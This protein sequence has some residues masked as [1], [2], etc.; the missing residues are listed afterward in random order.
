MTRL[1]T[2]QGRPDLT[3]GPYVVRFIETACVHGPGDVLGRQVEL[4]AEEKRFLYWA[5]ELEPDGRRVVR[6]AV[7]G[8]PK[9]S[10]KTEFAAWLAIAEMVGPVRCSGFDGDGNPVPVQ[11][12]DP[13]IPV[14]AASFE[15]ADLMFGAVR[16]IIKASPILEPLFDVY[17]T[18]IFLQDAPG[19]MFRIAAAAGTADGL[20]PTFFVGDET[21]E[22]TAR[23]KRVHLVV[24]NGLAKRQDA[25]SLDITTAGNPRQESVALEQYEYGRKVALG[26]VDD[27]RF[28]FDWRAPDV[29]L[30]DLDDPEVRA[31][32][33]AEANPEPWKHLDDLEARFHRIPLHEFARYHLNMW[34]EP[35]DERWLPPG[36][37]EDAADGRTP[38]D[39]ARVVLGFDGS[40]RGDCTALVG[41]TVEE[42]PTVFVLDVWEHPKH[43]PSWTVPRL[44]VDAA[45]RDA[46]A[47]F[48]VVELAADPPGWHTELEQWE[49]DFGDVVVRFETY[50]RKRMAAATSRFYTAVCGGQLSHDGDPT[51]ARHVDNCVLKE[52]A[53]GGYITK[54]SKSSPR[55][56]DAA[57]AAVIAT[58]RA[59]WHHQN[60]SESPEPFFMRG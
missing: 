14:A 56:I 16:E 29:N 36:V 37:W 42:H 33:I 32:A 40:Y 12:T 4:T 22:W 24:A 30:D 51:L 10:R 26:E 6:S 18:E 23:K 25:W 47:R 31:A 55:K 59:M 11:V 13:T 20:R 39:G 52:T 49:T 2:R 7:R 28:L 8:L 35:D 58:D 3:L 43:D 27:R 46:M 45:V 44:E 50:V 19:K 60:V 34:C 9:G 41:C 21:H 5:Y 17:D 38:D 53:Q 57:V 1:L 15:Q 48:D 54:E